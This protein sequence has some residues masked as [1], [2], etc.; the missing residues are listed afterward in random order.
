MKVL[1]GGR[2][3]GKTT[4]ML[5]WMLYA[6]PGVRRC[7]VTHNR[8]EARRVYEST[9]PA[10]WDGESPFGGWQFLSIQDVLR[11]PDCLQGR[12]RVEVGFDN[13]DLILPRLFRTPVA[14]GA[15]AMT[16]ELVNW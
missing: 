3:Q 12:Q 4:A 11:R 16:G 5:T 8:E 10:R 15:V 7:L 2:Q 9:F 1:V 6:P 13:L 14:V